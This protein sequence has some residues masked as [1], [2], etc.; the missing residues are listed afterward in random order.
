MIKAVIFDLGGVFI[1]LDMQKGIDS[2]RYEAGS[3][4]LADSL[5][6][7]HQKGL[8]KD[9]EAGILS[10]DDFY[11]KA[12]GLCGRPASREL[13]SRCFN[14]ILLGVD[15]A[16]VDYIRR[17]SGR[18]PL[19]ILSNNNPVTWHGCE[20]MMADAGLPLA[21]YFRECF[22]SYRFRILK[23]N[24]EIFI[25]SARRTGFKPSEILFIDDSSRN[26]E[27][28]REAG[29]HAAHYPIGSNLEEIVENAIREADENSL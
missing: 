22:I 20:R 21:E 8:F 5:D 17:L 19:F 28:A 25:Q 9:L 4:A 6:P 27:A 2:F 14:S 13:I 29:M 15:P 10:E 23:P 18:Y 16:K 3:D 7:C 1:D 26:V 12:V 24:L 11:E